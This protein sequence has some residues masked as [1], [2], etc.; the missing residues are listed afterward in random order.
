MI[1]LFVLRNIAAVN[2]YLYAQDFP[3]SG[4]GNAVFLGSNGSGKS[5]LLDAIQ[6]VMTGMNWRYLDL[7]SRVSDGGRNTRTVR[8]ACLGLLDDGQ[9]YERDACVTYIA[10]GFESADGSRQCTAGI[11]LEVKKTLSDE[12]VL[13]LFIVEDTIVRF[14]EFVNPSKDGFQE[15][16]WNSFLDEQ[17]RKQRTVRVFQRQNGSTFLRHLY[18]I[19]NANARGTQLDPNRARAAMRQALSF[20]IG[21]I[22]SVTEFVK[23]FLL[24][25][26]P[27]EIETFQARYT[28]WR[29]MQK[30][31]AG[32]EAEIKQVESIRTL[33]ERVLEDQF[34]LHLWTYGAQRAEYDR[35]G[36]VIARQK[37]EVFGMQEQLDSTRSYLAT[38]ADTIQSSRRHLDA[39][40]QQLEG[41]PASKQLR[42]AEGQREQQAA[43]R[44]AGNIQAK[45]LFDAFCA[46]REAACSKVFPQA[47]FPAIVNFA[48]AR[49]TSGAIGLY[50]ADWP[51][52]P[53]QLATVISALPEP[54][55][56]LAHI[57]ELHRQA[58]AEK[59]RLTGERVETER[60]LS[61]LR[62][63]GTYISK[64]TQDFLGDL[65][66]LGIPAHTLSEVADI[67]PAFSAWRAIIESILGDWVDAVIVEPAFMDRA[68]GH[69]DTHYKATQAKLIQTENVSVHDG[70][71][72]AGTLAE[73]LTTENRYARAFLNV[74]LG[75]IVRARSA[76]DIRKGDLAASQDG[77]YAHGRGIEYR[78]MRE[79][80]RLGKSVRD[81]QIA[82]LVRQQKDTEGKLDPVKEREARLRAIVQALKHATLI[83]VTNKADNLQILE[84][85]E[86]A[87]SE[88]QRQAEL[89]ADL[90]AKLPHGI[91]EEKRQLVEMLAKYCK[92]EEGEEKKEENLIREIGSRQ[93]AMKTNAE[94]RKKAGEQARDAIPGL[95]RR[96]CR[97]D[98]ALGLEKFVRRAREAYRKQRAALG[99]PSHVRNHFEGL[100][101]EKRSSQ[102]SAVSRLTIAAQEYV[103]AKPDQH[104]G[105]E[106]T[107]IV[108]EE[109]TELYDWINLRHRDLTETVLRNFK[110][111]VDKA[112]LALVETMVHDF[113][114]RL[115]AN[116]DSVERTKNDLNR[117][118]RD[119]VFMGEAYQIRHE[120]DQD[121]ETIRY[122]IDRLDIVAPKATALMQSNTDPHDQD[123]VKIKELIEMLTLENGDDAAARRRLYELA[124]YRNYFRFNI[125]I[126]D[127]ENGFRKISDLEQRRRIASGGQKYVPFYI[128]LGVAAA[129]AYHNHLGAVKDVPPQS[130]LLLMDEAFEKLDPDN[131]YKV[132]EFYNRLGLQLIMAAPKT[133]QAL[134]QETFNT[135]ISIIRARRAIQATAQ[136]FHPPAHELLRNENPMHKPRSYFEERVRW[137]RSDAAE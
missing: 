120:R 88:C 51:K 134:Y 91:V 92:E 24:D 81:Q 89:I 17:R 40:E 96:C 22:K 136:H 61:Q 12:N 14:K 57:E 129:S 31:I 114:S 64:D 87:D 133:H 32:V 19:I 37:Q 123:Q 27:I 104:P 41:I 111:Q 70:E 56:A 86:A 128:C 100:L 5:V 66:R 6:I 49:L 7:N 99:H 65:N 10:L 137:E 55:A 39:L 1:P 21:E 117:A 11:C 62:G 121:K 43:I 35:Y 82:Q 59:G 106:W 130:A 54:S 67:V 118:L 33:A 119:S 98:P 29:E 28:T 75:R 26:I 112:V 105:F 44:K 110:V 77:K 132:I 84:R 63:G 15:K 102:R 122:L 101:K 48:Q 4:R 125:D 108:E 74:R 126:C 103:L 80:P 20:D 45:P 127:A 25:D 42:A 3:I 34:N 23:R 109:R 47:A 90:E 97:H 58:D 13:G 69:F 2:F 116:I 113:L 38:L 46:F 83:L 68:Y 36:D 124:D 94:V 50:D 93:G 85:I 79:I 78:R 53:R 30:Q 76:E 71:I 16:T 9:G 131:I 60:L 72:R 8:D 52:N 107:K 73:A 18:A 115:S 135:L 95:E